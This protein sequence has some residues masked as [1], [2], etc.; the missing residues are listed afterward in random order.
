[1]C[2]NSLYTGF[3]LLR[4]FSETYSWWGCQPL[5]LP[6]C[7]G[8]FLGKAVLTFMQLLFPICTP[9]QFSK[10]TD[11]DPLKEKEVVVGRFSS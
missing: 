7:A 11:C 9:Q 6:R 10:V 8:L 2:F 1:M 3:R 5:P 4:V